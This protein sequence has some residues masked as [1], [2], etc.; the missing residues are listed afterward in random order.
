MGLTIEEMDATVMP[1]PSGGHAGEPE[2]APPS[3]SAS[4]AQSLSSD[5][6]HMIRRQ[7]RLRAD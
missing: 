2:K 4:G 5:M 1:E 7:L 3:A 6:R